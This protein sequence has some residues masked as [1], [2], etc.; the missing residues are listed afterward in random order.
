MA[1]RDLSRCHGVN[2]YRIISTLIN[3]LFII[4]TEIDHVLDIPSGI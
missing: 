1:D 2:I 3:K 4:L